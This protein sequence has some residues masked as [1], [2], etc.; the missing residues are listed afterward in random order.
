MYTSGSI[1]LRRSTDHLRTSPDVPNYITKLICSG[2]D[3][4]ALSTRTLNLVAA[5]HDQHV[6]VC[7]QLR[8]TRMFECISGPVTVNCTN[9]KVFFCYSDE[10]N[11]VSIILVYANS[12][13]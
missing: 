3:S 8:G 11:P 7:V 6:S 9:I 5:V 12:K 10:P 2:T 13:K 4:S 1:K